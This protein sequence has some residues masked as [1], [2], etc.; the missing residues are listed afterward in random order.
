MP[1][2]M[3]LM[4]LV[5][6]NMINTTL[7]VIAAFSSIL[8]IFLIYQLYLNNKLLLIL[9]QESERLLQSYIDLKKQHDGL[10]KLYED[11]LSQ[12]KES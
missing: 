3:V 5:S 7:L 10:I 4:E 12:H 9:D 8:S 2:P 6:E 11:K 1:Q